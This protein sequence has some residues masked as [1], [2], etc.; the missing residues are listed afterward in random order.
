MNQRRNL[1]REGGKGGVILHFMLLLL[2]RNRESSKA[3]FSPSQ[4]TKLCWNSNHMVRLIYNNVMLLVCIQLD[5]F[6]FRVALYFETVCVTFAKYTS[7]LSYHFLCQSES[8]TEHM[9]I[10]PKHRHA[11][12]SWEATFV[13][14]SRHKKCCTVHAQCAHF[15]GE[16]IVFKLCLDWQKTEV[17]GVYPEDWH[18]VHLGDKLSLVAVSP[19]GTTMSRPDSLQA[20]NI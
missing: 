10:F 13:W 18:L 16:T 4:P 14:H 5:F 9:Y 2:T 6:Y 3:Q 17:G 15:F 12:P 11:C 7:C 8:K 1:K 19:D 20:W